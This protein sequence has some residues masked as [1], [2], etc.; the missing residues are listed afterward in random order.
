[1]DSGW[2]LPH[3]LHN[4]DFATSG[5]STSTDIVAQHP[6]RRPHTLTRG[7]LDACFKASVRLL[8]VAGGL[9]PRGGVVAG[10]AVRP[11]VG[12]IEGGDNQTAVLNLRVRRAVGV[13]L[14]FIVAPTAS[15]SVEGPL[16]S[17]GR[18]TAGVVELITPGER[19]LRAGQVRGEGSAGS[20]AVR[21]RQG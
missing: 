5:P 16:G 15:A 13:V 2:L 12:F 9:D 21:E 3:V 20:A 6:E 7:N 8:E 14:K 4:V 11:G 18:G 10:D 1:M 17:V 19:P